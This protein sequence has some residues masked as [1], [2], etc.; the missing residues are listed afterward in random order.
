MSSK[1][2]T[3]KQCHNP[4]NPE[5]TSENIKLY[6]QPEETPLPVCAECWIKIADSNK[7]WGKETQKEPG[8]FEERKGPSL[9]VE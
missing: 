7:E 8:D 9:T 2:K 1:P 4:W 3:D 5:C 6:I